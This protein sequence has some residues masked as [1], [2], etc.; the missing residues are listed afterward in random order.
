MH[1]HLEGAHRGR[2]MKRIR[3]TGGA[4]YIGSH[5]LVALIEAG[6]TPVI[7]DGIPN[8]E[9]AVLECLQRIRGQ[10]ALGG[11]CAKRGVSG[12]GADAIFGVIYGLNDL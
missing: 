9:P 12:V 2:L 4:G 3:L 8:S 10:P 11:H 1:H 6:P 5:T 7:L